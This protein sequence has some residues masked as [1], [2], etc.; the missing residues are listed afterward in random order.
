[1]RKS[2]AVRLHWEQRHQLLSLAESPSTPPRVARRAR[3]ALRASDGAPNT[4]IARELG[5]NPVTVALW[6]HRFLAH[7]VAGVTRDAPR[8]GRPPAIAADRIQE[9]LSAVSEV[10]GSADGRTSVRGIAQRVGMSKSSVQRICHTHGLLSARRRPP[11][12][13]DRGMGFLETV[14]DL[15]GLYV[16]PPGRAVAFSTDE[17][18][19][20]IVPPTLGFLTSGIRPPADQ[21]REFRAFLQMMDRETPSVL[22]VHLLVDSRMSP[23]PPEVDHWL[24][25][26]PRFHLHPLPRDRVGLTLMDRLIDGFSRRKDRPGASASAH[27]LKYALR[28]HIRR[29][30][31][32]LA[33]FVWTATSGEIR[34][35]HGRRGDEI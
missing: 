7:G 31:D 23:V 2:A 19:R 29:N 28:E 10:R 12:G 9:V 1:M 24:S 8:S 34:G 6:R 3:I 30:R 17:R 15:V 5:T 26:H 13:S 27:R 4:V 35:A 32:P 16:N 20:S 14:T 33:T 22:E 21:G 11:R 25:R 18:M